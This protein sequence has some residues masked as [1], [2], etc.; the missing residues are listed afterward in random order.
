MSNRVVDLFA[1][2]WMGDR[3]LSAVVWKIASSCLMWCLWRDQNDR[4]FKNQKRK[5]EEFKFFSFSSLFSWTVA[6]LAPLVNSFNDFL[7]LSSSSFS[8]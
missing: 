1:F 7:V 5:L 3:S 2:W 8:F 4:T 6:F